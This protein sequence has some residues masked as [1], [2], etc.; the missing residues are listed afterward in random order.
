MVLCASNRPIQTSL[1]RYSGID[2]RRKVNGGGRI[3]HMFRV[4]GHGGT[5]VLFV[6]VKY[7]LLSKREY[8]N[9]VAQV[10]AESDGISLHLSIVLFMNYYYYYYYYFLVLLLIYLYRL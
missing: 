6:E 7:Q 8:L 5:A 2:D 4:F 9:A 3:V 10:I 1:C